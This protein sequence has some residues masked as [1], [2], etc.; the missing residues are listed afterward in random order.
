MLRRQGKPVNWMRPRT[1][2]LLPPAMAVTNT[3]FAYAV[4]RTTCTRT[5]SW[6]GITYALTPAGVRRLGYRPYTAPDQAREK[7]SIL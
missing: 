2:L 5:V 1:L 4:M 6:R 7:D 3:L